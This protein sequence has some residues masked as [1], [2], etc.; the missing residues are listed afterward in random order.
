MKQSAMVLFF[1][2]SAFSQ[3]LSSDAFCSL[4]REVAGLMDAWVLFTESGS[5]EGEGLLAAGTA[6]LRAEAAYSNAVKCTSDFLP[7]EVA[8]SW[9]TYLKSS[10]DC[11]NS[12]R[13]AVGSSSTAVM[14]DVVLASFA[15]WETQ[16]EEFLESVQSTR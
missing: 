7:E 6:I 10:A 3:P 8:V 5:L 2:V 11:I 4:D 9:V 15:R 14:G 1:F 12:L 16:G 13:K